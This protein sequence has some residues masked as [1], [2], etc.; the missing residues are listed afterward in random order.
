M[1]E[2]VNAQVNEVKVAQAK[3]DGITVDFLKEKAQ[4]RSLELVD[5]AIDIAYLVA[6]KKMKLFAEWLNE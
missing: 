5:D 6:K 1:S 2:Q 4:D 3:T